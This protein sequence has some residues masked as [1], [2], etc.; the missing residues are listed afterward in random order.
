MSLRFR[1]GAYSISPGL[2]YNQHEMRYMDWINNAL[3]FEIVDR[4]P[5]RTVF[6][7]THP[8]VEIEMSQGCMTG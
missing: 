1:P 6:G 8:E 7:L 5:G 3:V 2:S 4:Q